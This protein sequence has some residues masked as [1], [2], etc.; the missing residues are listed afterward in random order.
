MKKSKFLYEPDKEILNKVC[1]DILGYK[2]YTDKTTL[3]PYSDFIY[4]NIV[5]QFK[6]IVD[7]LNE[8]YIV[9]FKKENIKTVNDCIN[10]TR[11]LLKE[12]ELD[13]LLVKKMVK[14]ENVKYY[15]I[16][17][18]HMRKIIK[19]RYKSKIISFD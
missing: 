18:K 11:Q 16:S 15:K 14:G 10:I 9:K 6:E 5:L 13:L 12:V 2:S 7:L 19:N 8:Y 1:V 17:I 4:S 3:I